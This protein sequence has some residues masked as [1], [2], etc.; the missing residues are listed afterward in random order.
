MAISRKKSKE[1]KRVIG[2]EAEFRESHDQAA[3]S[4]KKVTG[5]AKEKP[6]KGKARGTS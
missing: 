5:T 4:T 1:D 2:T 3:A 6:A